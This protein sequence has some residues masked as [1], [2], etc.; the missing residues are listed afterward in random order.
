MTPTLLEPTKTF[1]EFNVKDKVIEN[2]LKAETE[3]Q[4][5]LR[6]GEFLCV[7]SKYK[8]LVTLADSSVFLPVDQYLP[9]MDAN[10]EWFTSPTVVL[11]TCYN[12]KYEIEPGFLARWNNE[13]NLFWY[14]DD[15]ITNVVAWMPYPRTFSLGTTLSLI[16]KLL[17]ESKNHKNLYWMADLSGSNELPDPS[18]FLNIQSGL[19]PLSV[20]TDSGFESDVCLVEYEYGTANGPVSAVSTAKLCFESENDYLYWDT[21]AFSGRHYHSSK[22]VAWKK[23]PVAEFGFFNSVE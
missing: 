8:K 5:S 16:E 21:S 18:K 13:D 11:L 7:D 6:P 22:V 2:L 10:D 23:L 1:K 3:L 19:P 14:E 12:G 17:S 20:K 9:L 15:V 4:P